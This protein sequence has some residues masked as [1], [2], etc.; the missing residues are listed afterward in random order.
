MQDL[1]PDK[2]GHILMFNRMVVVNGDW[3][4]GRGIL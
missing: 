3:K 2:P 4:S 1:I